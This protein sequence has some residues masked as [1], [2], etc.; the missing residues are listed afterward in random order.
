MN[1]EKIRRGVAP[2]ER[3]EGHRL[4]DRRWLAWSEWGPVDGR[5]VLLCTGA[6]LSG[7]LGFGADHLADMG[8]RLMAVDRP[9]LGDSA[10]HP[11][12]T[13]STWAEDIRE[14][15]AAQ[16]LQNLTAVGFSQGAPFALALAAQG[17]VEAVAVVSGQ[18]ELTHP[19]IKPMLHPEVAGM[20]EAIRADAAGFERQFAR[21]ATPAGL[22]QL[23][24]G[25][26]AEQD[27][28]LYL[29]EHFS[30]A[31]QRALQEGFAQGSQ[32][33]ARDLINAMQ[34]WP[35]ALEHIEVPVD[36]WYGALDS[37][38]VHSPDFGATLAARLPRATRTLDLEAGGS[39][40]WTKA[41]DILARLTSEVRK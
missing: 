10:P 34:P 8:L 27:R 19:G 22:W 7:W 4:S 11:G 16:Q 33:Y 32:G 5:P 13:L 31:F 37:S 29:D 3:R 38:M 2:P 25:M 1:T 17:L 36:L 6:A 15:K 39:I 14:L 41:Y 20:V 40:L 21:M 24:V 18:D 12:K 28:A 9:G 30:Q 23:I 26:S 35:F